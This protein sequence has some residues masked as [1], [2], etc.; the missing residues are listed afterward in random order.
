MNGNDHISWRARRPATTGRALPGAG[1]AEREQH[2]RGGRPARRGRARG[3]GAEDARLRSA[4]KRQR[5]GFA[6][7]SRRATPERP[8]LALVLAL[9]APAATTAAVPPN[10]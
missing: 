1:P 8:L 4:G 3:P 10:L 9:V 7:A 2:A 6:F 5:R